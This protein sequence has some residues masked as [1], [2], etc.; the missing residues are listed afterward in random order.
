MASGLPVVAAN[1]AYAREVCREAAL[2][3]DPFSAYD[4]ARQISRRVA[5]PQ[6]REGLRQ[7]GQSRVQQMDW[8]SH[9]R[10]LLQLLNE[11]VPEGKTR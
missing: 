5:D 7:R 9:V 1:L 8:G 2:Y 11:S 6:L 3:F 4:L 10:R